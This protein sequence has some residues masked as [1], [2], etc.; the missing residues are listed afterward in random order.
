[1]NGYIIEKTC[2]LC[3]FFLPSQNVIGLILGL[4]TQF[5]VYG[6]DPP[7][8]LGQGLMARAPYDQ[9][10]SSDYDEVRRDING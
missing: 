8:Q 1:M 7:P 10:L 4:F 3:D 6:V 5:H 2:V 9:C